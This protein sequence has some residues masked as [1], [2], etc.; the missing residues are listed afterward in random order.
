ML[1]M[2]ILEKVEKEPTEPEKKTRRS[3]TIHHILMAVFTILAS[4]LAGD[5]HDIVK[6]KVGVS[7]AWIIVGLVAIFLVDILYSIWLFKSISDTKRKVRIDLWKPHRKCKKLKKEIKSLI[8]ERNEKRA[9]Y[10]DII[11]EI[12]RETENLWKDY[13][14]ILENKL[15]ITLLDKIQRLV[16]LVKEH[17]SSKGHTNDFSKICNRCMDEKKNS[18]YIETLQQLKQDYTDSISEFYFLL[19]PTKSDPQHLYFKWEDLVKEIG[20]IIEPIG[21]LNSIIT[22]F[23]FSGDDKKTLNEIQITNEEIDSQMKKIIIE[24]NIRKKEIPRLKL[25]LINIPA[26]Q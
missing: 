4:L 16:L 15:R 6:E 23:T 21:T 25:N 19:P 12:E 17:H 3:F 13:D 24:Y 18:G 10:R 26:P 11:D 20:L 14:A 1:T 9:E 5:L 2:T 8:Q 22:V 7:M